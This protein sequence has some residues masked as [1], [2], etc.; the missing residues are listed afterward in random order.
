MIN[1]EY[2]SWLVNWIQA[3]TINIKTELPFTV[4]DIK[5]PEYKSAVEEKLSAS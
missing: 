3:G 2:V 4:D 5:R 1:Q